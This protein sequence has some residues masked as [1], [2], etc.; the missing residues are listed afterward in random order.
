[1]GTDGKTLGA[2]CR[3]FRDEGQRMCIQ[4]IDSATESGR[5]WHLMRKAVSGGLLLVLILAGCAQKAPPPRVFRM[6][7]RVE[8]GQLVYNVFEAE[9]RPVLTDGTQTRIPTHRF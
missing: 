8:V 3:V 5:S 1:V 7:E 9:W 2:A 4:P 6:G